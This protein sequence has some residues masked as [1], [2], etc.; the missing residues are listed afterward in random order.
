MSLALT[1]LLAGTM[2]LAGIAKLRDPDG[3][4]VVL[5]RV[6]GHRVPGRALARSLAAVEIA[7]GVALVLAAGSPV[8]AAATAVLLVAF[9]VAL[10][11]AD[12][13]APQALAA[14]NCFGAAG[15]APAGQALLRNAGLI[16]AA[17]VVALTPPGA[18]WSVAA[19]ELAGAAT[20]AIGLT[21]LWQLATLAWRLRPG[22]LA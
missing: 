3:L 1:L 22:A 19:D 12:D 9:S 18:P 17:V 6:V 5:R 2:V 16:V 11:V 13:R 21:C 20:V 14:C 10:R 8:P 4:V 7:L 15:D